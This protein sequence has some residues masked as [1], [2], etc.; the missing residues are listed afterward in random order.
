MDKLLPL[1]ID[2]ATG[3]LL[4]QVI[5]PSVLDSI[6]EDP[7]SV[8]SRTESHLG[9]AI[10][11]P[12][13]LAK[14]GWCVL[15]PGTK[16]C[17]DLKAALKPLLDMRAAQAGGL[18][19]ILEKDLGYQP[20][21][22][23]EQWLRRRHLD[24]HVVKPSAGVPYYVMIVGS[25]E[26]I[27]FEFQYKLDSYWAVGRIWF[28]TIGEYAAY[29]SKAAAADSAPS[30]KSVAV[31]ATRHLADEATQSLH[32]FLAAPMVKGGGGDPPLGSDNGFAL[33]PLL[34]ADATKAN[35][36]D[37]LGGKRQ[38]GRPSLIFSGSH[39]VRF[40]Q[41]D[42]DQRLKQGA[43]LC[44]DFPRRGSTV[45]PTQYI[46][47]KDLGDV[48]L[49]GL[50]YFFFACYSAGCPKSDTYDRLP[51]RS[52][53]P[54]MDAP[55]VARLPQGLL[56]RGAL[57]VIGHIDRAWTYSFVG[58]GAPQTQDFRFVLD[59]LMGGV[60]IGQAMDEFNRRWAVLSISLSEVI[61]KRQIPG[62][63]SD[64]DLTEKW[65]ARNDARNYV[66]LG[67]PAARLNV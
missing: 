65:K 42:A 10:T 43:L 40:D 14:A 58:A 9:A 23:A 21:D 55:I 56:A 36:L 50:I 30:V 53:K 59:Q 64:D 22:T 16:D 1:G 3:D 61:Q 45:D 31:V 37:L 13:D 35:I 24:F 25:P 52:E 54:L 41:T 44:A 62:Q 19:K 5:P 38:G 32:D 2:A 67:D 46:T 4:P 6:D 57:A 47:E 17:T 12:N 60:R 27:P 11:D 34:A 29:A 7:D 66:I 39:G 18:F 15:F 8:Q 20:G 51:D 48:V 28:E 49:D 33:Q 26:E 63:V